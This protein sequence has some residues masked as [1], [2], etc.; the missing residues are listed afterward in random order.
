MLN[1]IV[2]NNKQ[3]PVRFC[4]NALAEFCRMN[5]MTLA[6]MEKMGNEMTLDMALTLIYCGLKHG[7]RYEKRAFD[8]DIY[9]I[10]DMMTDNPEMLNDCMKAFGDSQAKPGDKKKVMGKK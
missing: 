1:F 8:F 5:N 10:G 4:F 9:D 7:A 2:I 6:Q 3:H